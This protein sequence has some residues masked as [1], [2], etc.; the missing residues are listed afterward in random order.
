MTDNEEDQET[1][2]KRKVEELI[3]SANE[4]GGGD[5][6]TALLVKYTG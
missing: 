3:D 1:E 6:I 4:G 5:N 2:L